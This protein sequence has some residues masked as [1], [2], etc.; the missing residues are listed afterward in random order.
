MKPKFNI[1]TWLSEFT[2]RWQSIIGFVGAL[3]IVGTVA[4]YIDHWKDNNKQKDLTIHYLIQSDSLDKAQTKIFQDTVLLSLRRLTRGQEYQR[5]EQNI[6]KGIMIE[7]FK[8]TM[9]KDELVNMFNQ[10]DLKKNGTS[11]FSIPYDPNRSIQNQ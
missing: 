9:S 2:K 5:K 3:V 6:I 10:F 8:K 7:Q 1:F 11:S 4:I